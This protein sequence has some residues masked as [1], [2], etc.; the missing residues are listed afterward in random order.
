MTK[1][2]LVKKWFVCASNDLYAAVSLFNSMCPKPL[3]IICN[4][5]Q[6]AVEKA[7]KGFLIDQDIEPPCT[8]DLVELCGM[9]AKYEPSFDDDILRESCKI[10]TSYAY[11]DYPGQINV[12]E[13]DALFATKEA[14]KIYTLCF[15]MIPYLQQDETLR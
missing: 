6:Q 7:L 5:S 11:V 14:K 13:K 4:S 3:E 2:D 1:L 9:C 15:E 12:D 8:H 10:L